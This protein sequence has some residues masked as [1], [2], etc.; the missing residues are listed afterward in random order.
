M[1]SIL[2]RVMIILQ[3]VS[4][5]STERFGRL[6]DTILEAEKIIKPAETR[7]LTGTTDLKHRQ[8]EDFK[9]IQCP[10]SEGIAK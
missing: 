6:V 1:G 8:S 5:R 2:N 9:S 4:E 10:D 7:R 3:A